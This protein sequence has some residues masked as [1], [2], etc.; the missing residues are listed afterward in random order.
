MYATMKLRRFLG[1]YWHWALLAPLLMALEVAMDLLQPRLIQHIID[2]GVARGNIDVV[3]STGLLQIGVAI[4]GVFGGVGCGITAVLAG[5]GFGADLRAT[6]FNKVQSLSFGNLDRLETG[7][8]ITRL[9]NDITQVQELVML[10]LRIMVRVPLMLVGSLVLAILT[11]PRLALIFLVLAPLIVAVLAW[12]INRSFPLFGAVQRRLDTLNTV[13]QEN[14]AGVRVVKAF[15]R[16]THERR[17]FGQ[18]NDQ[19]MV[20][21]IQAVRVGAITMPFMMLALNGGVVAALWFGGV[22]VVA[23]DLLIGELV[24]FIN[25]LTQTLMS[26]MMISM[27]VMRFARAEASAVRIHEVF[28]QQPDVPDAAAPR[29]FGQTCGHVAFEHVSFGYA[30][31]PNGGDLVLH[32][33]SFSATPG[34]TVAL[35]GATGAGKSSLVHLIPRFYDAHSG[36]V[37]IDGV[38]VRELD[39]A[40]LRRRVAIALQEAILFSGSIRENIRYGRPDASDAEVEQAARLAQAHDFVSRLPAGYDA[41]VGQRGVN[42]SGGQKQRLALARALLARP[43]VLVLDDATS[44]VDVATEARI[45]QALTALPDRPTQIVVAQRISSVLH[46][47]T[48]L[49]LDK[50]QIV[51][52][53]SH[54]ELIRTSPIYREIYD[55]QIEHGALGHD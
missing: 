33:I 4:I 48:I 52:R 23:G 2:E 25:Y 10:L 42:L 37:L 39:Q 29:S 53:G 40:E 8:L 51:A 15:A 45:Q 1:H 24:A 27:L 55:S 46:A 43:A 18:A 5:Q 31:T 54:A 16:H 41:I 19:L 22:T 34:Q 6:L 47:D 21:N 12:I 20:Q 28:D 49:V 50:G 9:T 32:D 36:R 7:G 14:L 13:M 17:R 30:A 26:L 44:A 35:L 38:D 11:S 3:I